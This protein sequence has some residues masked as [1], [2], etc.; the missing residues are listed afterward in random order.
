MSS[1]DR[2]PDHP[3]EL[4]LLD[5]LFGQLPRETTDQI[6][7]H[8]SSCRACRRTVADLSLTVEELDRLP[9]V[10][11]P[12]D[13]PYD[14][15]PRRRRPSRSRWTYVPA[16]L[17]LVIGIGSLA[18]Y[19]VERA[20]RAAT[21]DTVTEVDVNATAAQLREAAA[22]DPLAR[23]YQDV[24]TNTWIV[25]APRKSLAGIVANV[26]HLAPGGTPVLLV[27]ADG[28]YAR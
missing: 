28:V 23:V 10:A 6:K 7:R 17:I 3:E 8:V 24:T 25:L 9:T 12:H 21:A 15:E 1:R 14:E 22:V 5:Y 11:I 27:G 2:I 18:L 19:S 4:L 13:S 16:I 20:G 26:R